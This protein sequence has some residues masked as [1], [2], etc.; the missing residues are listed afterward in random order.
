MEACLWRA[1]ELTNN[2]FEINLMHT[3]W[4]ISR[5]WDLR[6]YKIVIRKK[7]SFL[8]QLLK[9]EHQ[10]VTCASIRLNMQKNISKKIAW[11]QNLS[12]VKINLMWPQNEKMWQ[13]LTI[14]QL[15]FPFFSIICLVFVFWCREFLLILNLIRIE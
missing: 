14:W 5:D 11:T 1:S 7:P 2:S 10:P 3:H 6:T 8:Y 13:C 4:D 9:M 15:R 12:Y